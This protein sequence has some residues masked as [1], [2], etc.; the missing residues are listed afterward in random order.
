M[1]SVCNIVSVTCS[2]L[3]ISLCVILHPAAYKNQAQS[4]L[5]TKRWRTAWCFSI[6]VSLCSRHFL[7]SHSVY[8]FFLIK[9]FSVAQKTIV[10]QLNKLFHKLCCT[11]KL[12]KTKKTMLCD[13][14]K[15]S[16]TQKKR[17]MSI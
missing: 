4:E 11:K 5:C 2:Q 16:V 17:F 1:K 15:S 13:Y 12:Y 6:T 14:K 7:C 10:Y 8:N 3:K 9:K